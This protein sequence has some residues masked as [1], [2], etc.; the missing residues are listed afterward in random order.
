MPCRHVIHVSENRITIRAEHGV[1]DAESVHVLEKH[2]TY[3]A[4]TSS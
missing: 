3:R 2:T 4:R 1:A